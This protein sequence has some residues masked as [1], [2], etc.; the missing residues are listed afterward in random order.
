[1]SFHF[2]LILKRTEMMFDNVL[3]KNEAFLEYKNV[4]LP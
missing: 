4:T 3:D 1:M 2:V